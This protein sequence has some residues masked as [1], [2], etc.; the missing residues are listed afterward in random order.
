MVLESYKNVSL[1][2]LCPLREERGRMREMKE[3]GTHPEDAAPLALIS[4]TRHLQHGQTLHGTTPT[5]GLRDTKE[6]E[7]E[8]RS[9]A[10]CGRSLTE[11]RIADTCPMLKIF[12][13]T[14]SWDISFLPRICDFPILR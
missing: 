2:E 3:H 13:I 6:E 14:A 9:D 1:S 7:R 12:S 10:A 5:D 11:W 4:D 8:S